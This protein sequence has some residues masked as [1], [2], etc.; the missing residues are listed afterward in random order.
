MCPAED[1]LSFERQHVRWSCMMTVKI[2][3]EVDVLVV[4]AG[5][6]GL[7]AAI[8]LGRYGVDTLLVEQ[9][10]K[11]SFLPR[12][13]GLGTRTI[14]PC[15]PGAS[16]TRSSPASSRPTCCCGNA[17]RCRMSP[18]AAL[19]RLAIQPPP[20]G[21]R[22]PRAPGVVPPDSLE[23]VLRRHIDS[24]PT[25]RLEL[26]TRVV[27]VDEAVGSVQVTLHDPHGHR[28]TIR[29]RYLVAADGADSPIR[30]MLGVEMREWDGA[31]GGTQVL[32]TPRW[33]NC[34]AVSDRVVRRHDGGCARPVP[35]GWSR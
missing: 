15:A 6:A 23:R 25:V 16:S 31:Y 5:P 12:A 29:A 1:I 7:A 2:P 27:A 20:G 8:T 3:L 17:R 19:T 35:A 24:L 22:Q 13:T 18:Q 33:H 21:R 11:P 9:R 26:G 4:G 34:S 32:F 14:E 28:Q 10:V 30:R